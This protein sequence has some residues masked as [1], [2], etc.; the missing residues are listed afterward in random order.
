ML[1]KSDFAGEE[2]SVQNAR[3][4]FAGLEHIDHITSVIDRLEAMVETAKEEGKRPHDVLSD[5]HMLFLGP[6]G[7]G[8]TEAAKRFAKML[9]QLELLPTDR[10]EYTTAG[11][12]IDRYIGG[13]GNNTLEAMRRAKGGVLFIDEAYAMLPGKGNW[14]GKEILHCLLENVT[15]EEFKGKII[16]ILG[17]YEDAIT[18]LF[19]M[20]PGFQSR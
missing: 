19:A 20:N 4:A 17:G 15:T 7:A 5:C 11:N 13:T 12:L 6:P 16:I 9:M 3:D 10:F 14:F 18:Q 1:I 2:T 8:K